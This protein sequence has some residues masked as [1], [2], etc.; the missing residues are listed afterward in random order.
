MGISTDLRR[1][2]GKPNRTLMDY[3]KAG[4]LIAGWVV[5]NRK[6][7]K[8]Q[9][10][11]RRRVNYVESLAGHSKKIP[12]SASTL[13]ACYRLATYWNE[14]TAEATDKAGIPFHIA[15]QLVTLDATAE[16]LNARHA[17]KLRRTRERL[18]KEYTADK[19]DKIT[20]AELR[21]EVR[22]KLDEVRLGYEPYALRRCRDVRLRCFNALK[23]V[24]KQLDTVFPHVPED[25]QEMVHGFAE[26]ARAL[27]EKVRN[28]L[29]PQG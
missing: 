17:N 14:E 6:R 11:G 22:E 18:V 4:Q 7:K 10:R 19:A 2:L 3:W 26:E 21:K 15:V 24:A 23:Q 12:C 29:R 16:R 25:R 28:V 20:M 27:A 13:R 8:D 9:F 1:T 5:D